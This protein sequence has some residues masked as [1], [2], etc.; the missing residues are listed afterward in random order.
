MFKKIII[1]S[2]LLIATAVFAGK[3]GKDY[4][5]LKSSE[6]QNSLTTNEICSSPYVATKGKDGK[7]YFV[8]KNGLV[9]SAEDYPCN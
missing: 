8:L 6:D 9:F 1:I 5:V 3:D 4:F 7:D 2:S